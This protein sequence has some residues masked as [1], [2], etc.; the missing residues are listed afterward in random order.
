MTRIAATLAML[1]LAA[2]SGGEPG[3]PSEIMKMVVAKD[4]VK[5]RLRDPDSAEFENLRMG[6]YQGHELVCGKV[7]SKNGFG[8]MVGFQRFVTN[9]G[10]ATVLEESMSEVEFAKTWAEAGC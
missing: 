7:N 1:L 8:G 2:C 10:E 5:A 6:S 3:E 9:G 4:A